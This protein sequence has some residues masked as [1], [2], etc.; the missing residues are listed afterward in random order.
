MKFKIPVFYFLLLIIISCHKKEQEPV[1]V[2]EEKIILKG[3]TRG[4]VVL[5]D[6]Y[7]D[8][9]YNVSNI[10]LTLETHPTASVL[11]DSIGYYEFS[12]YPVGTYT[13]RL[14]KEGF[15]VIRVPEFVIKEG[16]ITLFPRIFMVQKSTARINKIT[17]KADSSIE[18]YTWDNI[19][20]SPGVPN[21]SR[22][23][24]RVCSLDSSM[25]ITTMDG[26]FNKDRESNNI[27]FFESRNDT[28][29]NYKAVEAFILPVAWRG[30]KVFYKFYA[31]SQSDYPDKMPAYPTVSD[32]SS[33]YFFI[34]KR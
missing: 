18:T 24:I 4:Q 26:E 34:L 22:A 19:I 11:T 21:K 17:F 20:L 10:K 14:E 30:K 27:K 12:N 32:S 6:E 1:P 29:K 31:L 33:V 13:V 3:S 28:I 2:L 25:G 7:G 9:K 23:I 15:P 8:L 16:I 5:Y